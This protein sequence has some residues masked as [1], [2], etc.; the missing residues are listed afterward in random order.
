M[1]CVR[2]AEA[3]GR[4]AASAVRPSGLVVVL[5]EGQNVVFGQFLGVNPGL[6]V[7][8]DDAVHPGPEEPLG[9]ADAGGGGVRGLGYYWLSRL[10]AAG[11]TRCAEKVEDAP[12]GSSRGGRHLVGGFFR[13]LVEEELHLGV[14][15]AGHRPRLCREKAEAQALA[16]SKLGTTN[17]I[18]ID[19]R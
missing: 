9:V 5:D 10:C 6:R 3:V 1:H 12:E 17:R 8:D 11:S 19:G 4:S 18:S 2:R 14:F 15:T 7:V 16:G 13:L